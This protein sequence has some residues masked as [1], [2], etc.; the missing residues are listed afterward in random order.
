MEDIDTHQRLMLHFGERGPVELEVWN[1]HTESATTITSTWATDHASR[2]DAV[3]DSP[4]PSGRADPT[5]SKD[6]TRQLTTLAVGKLR[7]KF[8][9]AKRTHRAGFKLVPIE[10][11]E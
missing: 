9:V 6:I 8:G 4:L 1:E 5:E 10:D 11:D 3:S 7:E 2:R